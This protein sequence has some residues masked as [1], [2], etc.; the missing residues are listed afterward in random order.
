MVTNPLKTTI[1]SFGL[2]RQ[3]LFHPSYD[4]DALV[5]PSDLSNLTT[6][7]PPHPPSTSKES[8]Y[9]PP[10]P[11]SNMSVWQL[12]WWLNSGSTSKSEGE[13]DRSVNNVLNAN[14]FRLED[15]R[16]FSSHHENS[17]LDATNNTSPLEDGF[18]V[19]S[20]T[21]EVPTGKP[22][23]LSSPRHTYAIP[24]LHYWKLL[25][26]IKAAFQE[27]LS[28]QFHFTPFSLTHRSPITNKEQ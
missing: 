28:C 14:D 12:M 1:N 17:C 9:D 20:V 16:N 22:G 11:F 27:P 13:V 5:D 4:P 8:N 10:S 26:I 21:I 3:Y 19:T 24:G 18:Q 7:T 2:F 6:H 25:N 15:L 23:D